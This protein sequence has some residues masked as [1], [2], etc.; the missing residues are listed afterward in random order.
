MCPIGRK[1]LIKVAGRRADDFDREE[2]EIGLFSARIYQSVKIETKLPILGLIMVSVT[3][4]ISVKFR[5]IYACVYSCTV[6]ILVRKIDNLA[7]FRK[8]SIAWREM[9]IRRNF[10][11]FF[12][13]L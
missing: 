11:I 4:G 1:I 5:V 12:R 6:S 3:F 2:L 10:C 13:S 8:F 9:L 7:E